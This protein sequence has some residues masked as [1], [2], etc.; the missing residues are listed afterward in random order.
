MRVRRNSL[1][2]STNHVTYC[3]CGQSTTTINIPRV[4]HAINTPSPFPPTFQPLINP[5]P[6]QEPPA[7]RRPLCGWTLALAIVQRPCHARG[8]RW[9]PATQRQQATRSRGGSI[10]FAVPASL[11][12]APRPP[13]GA[14]VATAGGGR[15]G[16]GVG[17]RRRRSRRCSGVAS[18]RLEAKKNK[19][20]AEEDE[21]R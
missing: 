9:V 20:K 2:L 15:E 10:A 12:V 5:E 13:A 4:P 21:F 17:G 11:F 18:T 6:D 19:V 7:M 3:C 14:E 1:S 16:R 8:E